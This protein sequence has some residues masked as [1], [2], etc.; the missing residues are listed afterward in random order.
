[1]LLKPEASTIDTTVI[2]DA[3][4]E[5]FNIYTTK[6]QRQGHFT[7]QLHIMQ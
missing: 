2:L 1:M 5:S 7:R 4:N 6:L 3:D